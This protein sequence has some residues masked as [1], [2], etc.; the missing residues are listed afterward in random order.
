MP[1]PHPPSPQPGGS[2]SRGLDLEHPCVNYNT[3]SRLPSVASCT[4]PGY[5]EGSS[6]RLA[7]VDLDCERDGPTPVAST[8]V[9]DFKNRK[10]RRAESQPAACHI[11][12]CLAVV[13]ESTASA[14]LCAT[15]T[16][17]P[18]GCRQSFRVEE[19]GAP[20]LVLGKNAVVRTD[21]PA[22]C[23]SQLAHCGEAL[24]ARSYFH[25]P[26]RFCHR[27]SGMLSSHRDCF[28]SF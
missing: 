18:L 20:H 1:D 6:G 23:S 13:Q 21:G 17:T 24:K 4:L 28:A 7:T 27:S 25:A 9:K 14:L 11:R 19:L 15:A 16:I 5:S 26:V 22:S 2:T 3:L 10:T 8:G 12:S